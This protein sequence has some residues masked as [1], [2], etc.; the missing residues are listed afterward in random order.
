V[1][2]YFAVLNNMMLFFLAKEGHFYEHYP[3]IPHTGGYMPTI[4]TVSPDPEARR[5]LGL[6][7]ELKGFDIIQEVDVQGAKHSA[8]GAQIMLLDMVDASQW[9]EAE[10]AARLAK[11]SG[12]ALAAL[13]LPRGFQGDPPTGIRKGFGLIIR[14]PY[15]LMDLI[16]RTIAALSAR[17][18]KAP[19]PKKSRP[20]ARKKRVKKA[21]P[22]KGKRAK[23]KPKG[24]KKKR[25]LRKRGPKRKQRAK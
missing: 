3:M 19:P 13:L 1:S 16:R 12:C 17:T 9:N 23:G 20:P 14:K 24:P 22:R 2:Q 7:F 25:P 8:T 4:L 15:E 5:M 6:G 21:A 11:T 18:K 10:A